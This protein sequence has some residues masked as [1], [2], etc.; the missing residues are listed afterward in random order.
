[1]DDSGV[2]SI[3]HGVT[4]RSNNS[5]ILP[6]VI[7]QAVQSGTTP[8][9]EAEW[10]RLANE[11]G[12]PVGL[13]RN[14]APVKLM[15]AQQ[16]A[17]ELSGTS[18]VTA[19]FL[20]DSNNAAVAHDSVKELSY[21][22][23]FMKKPMQSVGATIGQAIGLG[24]MP[25]AKALDYMSGDTTETDSLIK[26]MAEYHQYSKDAAP[27]QR[28]GTVGH[29]GRAVAEIA[30]Y[31]LMGPVGV[32]AMTGGATMDKIQS[33]A[34]AGVDD[35]TNW[36]SSWATGL[37]AYG[38]TKL[39]FGAKTKLGSIG[40]GVGLNTGFGVGSRAIDSAILS[41]GG[42]DDLADKINPLDPNSMV[43]DAVMGALFGGHAAYDIYAKEKTDRVEAQQARDFVTQ[44]GT[45]VT[46][47]KVTKRFEPAMKEFLRLAKQD[48][49]V[50]DVYMP[51]QEWNTLWQDGKEAPDEAARRVLGTDDGYHESLVLGDDMKIP[52]ETFLTEFGKRKDFAD[53]AGKIKVRP[54]GISADEAM[55]RGE[56]DS[57]RMAEL[58]RL[59]KEQDEQSAADAT[60]ETA[61]ALKVYNDI[62]GQIAGLGRYDRKTAEDNSKIATAHVLRMA[63]DFKQDPWQFWQNDDLSGR[64]TFTNRVDRVAAR[65]KIDMA[66]DPMLDTLRAEAVSGNKT[67]KDGDLYT[68]PSLLSFVRDRGVSDDRGDLKSMEVDSNRLPGQKNILRED[69]MSLDKVR[70][71][72]VEQGYLPE[73]STTND[74]TQAI[75]KEL[76]GQP[77]YPVG[78]EH[79]A[80]QEKQ[81][82]FDQMRQLLDAHGVDLKTMN[83][84][85][86]RKV[87]NGGQGKELFQEAASKAD[88]F[89]TSLKEYFA[90]TLN[91]K[92]VIEVGIPSSALK[93]AGVKG[94]KIL[95]KQSI[96][97]RKGGRDSAHEYSY[98]SLASLPE[99]INDPI[100]V[101]D[102]G[103]GHKAIF[104]E[105]KSGGENLLVALETKQSGRDIE[106]SRIVTMFGK[107]P[108]GIAKWL[109]DGHSVWYN[110]QKA[111]DWLAVLQPTV[112]DRIS[113][114][115]KPSDNIKRFSDESVKSSRDQ[116]F[117][118][119]AWHGGPH[120]FDKF[121]MDKVGTGEGVQSFGHGLY[122]AGS[123]DV[124]KWY[125]DKLSRV[126]TTLVVDGK[127]YD[128]S[129][130]MFS[131]AD[132]VDRLIYDA[133]NGA[134]KG[135][136]DKK[137][138]LAELKSRE[139]SAFKEWKPIFKEAIE[140]L[141]SD[142]VQIEADK[143]RLYKVE[144]AP[145]EDEYLL[146]GK[147]FSEQS[148]VV[149]KALLALRKN[150]ELPLG[151]DESGKGEGYTG[152]QIYN[153]LWTDK[154][155]N[156]KKAEPA[157]EKLRQTSEYLHSLG[158]RG[159]KYLDGTSRSE[160][161]GAHNYVIFNDN[162]VKIKQMWQKAEDQKRG[163]FRT[164][165]DS[166][167]REIGIL[168]D[169]NATTFVHEVGHWALDD[170]QRLSAHPDAP[171]QVKADWATVSKWL[172]SEDGTLSTE[173]HEK[174][175]DGMITFF[176]EGKAPSEGLRGAFER[177]STWINGIF[178]KLSDSGVKINDDVREVMGRMFATDSEIARAR[179]QV[180]QKPLFA[181]AA[182]MGM[183]EKEFAA[184]KR[185]GEQ[186]GEAAREKLRAA[187]LKEFRRQH[188]EW[189]KEEQTKINGQVTKEAQAEPVYQA[190][191]E[192][193]KGRDFA[194]NEVAPMK[195]D[196]SLLVDRYGEDFVKRLPKGVTGKDGVHPD[197][198]AERFGFD[199]ADTM[200]KR[201]IETPSY[202][203][204][205][206]QETA[207]R[208]NDQHGAM[209][210]DGS[211]VDEAT[212]AVHNEQ[213][214]KVLEAEI[215][216]LRAK[217]N[218]VKPFVNAA[219]RAAAEQ[220][221]ESATKIPTYAEFRETAWRHIGE[222]DAKGISP[223]KYLVAERQS[224][225][226]AFKLNGEGKY[227]LAADARTRQLLNHFM[228]LEAS[229]AKAEVKKIGDYIGIVSKRKLG[230][231]GK[232]DQE[233][234]GQVQGILERFGVV[235][236][237]N[238]AI[239]QPFRDWL[240]GFEE[241][242]GTPLPID[243]GFIENPGKQ[244]D[245]LK[246]NELRSVRDTLKMIETAARDMNKVRV[247]GEMVDRQLMAG[248]MS[249]SVY[250][251][252]KE[253]K[254]SDTKASQD[255]FEKYANYPLDLV[256]KR[257][258]FI[259]RRLDNYK[260]IGPW[261]DAL[262]N[263][264]NDA[265]D[266]QIRLMQMVY[267]DIME[268]V[269]NKGFEG[270][271]DRFNRPITHRIESIDASLAKN[272][273]IAIALNCGNE[274]NMDKLMR[275]GL[276]LEGR[277]MPLELNHDQIQEIL[278]HLTAKDITSVNAIWKTIEKLKPEAA[279]LA[280]RRLGVEPKWIE[281]QPME[282]KNGTLEGG[283]FPLKYDARWSKAG[284]LQE[285]ASTINDLF[286]YKGSNTKQGYMKERNEKASLPLDLNW[287]GIVTRHLN[288][289]IL[290]ISHWQFARDARRLLNDEQVNQ[291]L[292]DRLGE[293][294]S[295]NLKGW[296]DQTITSDRF[297]E[298]IEGFVGQLNSLFRRNMSTSLL[299]LR[300][301]NAISEVGT[302][303]V[304]VFKE[305]S[306]SSVR[307][308][309]V[310]YGRNRNNAVNFAESTS[311]FL[312]NLS[313]E[314]DR[315]F[316]EALND[317]SGRHSVANDIKKFGMMTK[318]FFYRESA[319][320]GWLSGYQEGQNRGYTE[321]QSR[322]FADSVVRITQVSGRKGDLSAIE[323]QSNQWV[324]S[325][326]QFIGPSLVAYN[327]YS[328]A[329][330]MIKDKGLTKDSTM[331]AVKTF[332][333][334]Y[335]P[336]AV[337]FDLIRG[338]YPDDPEKIPKWLLARLTFG[339]ADGIP[340]IR[341]FAKKTEATITGEH[342]TLRPMPIYSGIESLYDVTN[343]VTKDDWSEAKLG[344]KAAG[345]VGMVT[346]LPTAQATV[347]GEFFHDILDGSYDPK[348]AWSPVTDTFNYHKKNR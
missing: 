330:T 346:G 192:L 283:Y 130:Q 129:Q 178:Q 1:M 26:Q 9:Q 37:G 312:K 244:L 291:A 270:R 169:A 74:L 184:Y 105:L 107:K 124:A 202:K 242:A 200:I 58:D 69:G 137:N 246:M 302:Q 207:A 53:L 295:N 263:T 336:Q 347:T 82:R 11:S 85:D 155:R 278:S 273:I 170:L 52:L 257:R 179:E 66:T 112:S 258:E 335:L 233:M 139:K 47:N 149:Q 235:P 19:Q 51:V 277:D 32:A 92:N 45:E 102:Q 247:N 75:D 86:V 15:Q 342:Y 230:D 16:Q 135:Y 205:V 2:L 168:K 224:A 5:A 298:D 117:Y 280:R 180:D 46:D 248:K 326:T 99:A 332:V 309:V 128:N 34:D 325:L 141:K 225:R 126:N 106:V 253:N 77:V 276:K 163:F 222:Q 10:Q 272:D 36:I 213:W 110:E 12:V 123:K 171:E 39:P 21:I 287:S 197:I 70:E 176:R 59:I 240:A 118:Q 231:I 215:K 327:H 132:K 159:I 262:M 195:I 152:E 89:R 3:I 293:K 127:A 299:G 68:A 331:N 308:A 131:D 333:F 57:G 266:H 115:L 145:K 140:K 188:L 153:Q 217:A 161:E 81:A 29:V 64:V 319:A 4:G 8:D 290:D 41:R 281:A 150:T 133:Y 83:N 191:Q 185:V 214:S 76:R 28:L 111:Q 7:S 310:A 296:I 218:Q 44:L 212:V 175:A 239:R 306:V 252:G 43:H 183:G 90:K 60:H 22:E 72:A 113:N 199:S 311:P 303:A 264:Y 305:C 136:R 93:E 340:I 142:A 237:D 337:M 144:L 301:G 166:P 164:S 147:S 109:E 300:I 167:L 6:A 148:P 193:Q 101:I 42:Y 286:T 227:D 79:T 313:H 203:S 206:A 316:V 324:R 268:I 50:Q 282:I 96:L 261:H 97:N 138:V 55:S 344:K 279:A 20:S 284:K 220:R 61:P 304:T 249:R 269:R 40:R 182:D 116:I 294:Y 204:Y 329:A 334:M 208:M 190:I 27:D 88:N 25:I 292:Q 125:R 223:Y 241:R 234:L 31:L 186:A 343:A 255:L 285:D 13:V 198:V 318:M 108:E 189:W 245:Q 345:A 288:D 172:K 196:R 38:M 162:D 348:H 80:N 315:D 54:D 100:M 201:M 341:D 30:P 211:I 156:D 119:S 48:G 250:S 314:I 289:V 271:T 158:I 259:F 328:E 216:A 173:Q 91:P 177:L 243:A 297:S 321:E 160:G 84:E 87:L 317:L 210:L 157:K 339:F 181:T 146:W 229:R 232:A 104:T 63:D 194:G 14:G 98:E 143:G 95:L 322:R 238:T 49:P 236:P 254:K 174:F 78:S 35:G 18:P 187:S 71:A 56:L 151:V 122:F 320:L 62:Y 228:F 121:S 260:D 221:R 120:T 219:D 165:P 103:D 256:L 226:D 114:L 33:N 134:G 17:R 265:A 65:Q 94:E 267:P 23:E 24:M 209:H 274:S 307:D 73:G 323:G 251:A 338:K 154:I 275:N 67:F